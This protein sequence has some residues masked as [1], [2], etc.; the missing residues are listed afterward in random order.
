VPILA[1]HGSAD[2]IVPFNGGTDGLYH[3]LKFPPLSYSIDLWRSLDVCPGA[4]APTA[5]GKAEM[6]NDSTF[7]GGP[8]PSIFEGST[9]VYKQG[10]AEC[11]S[12]TGC[13]DGSEVE[14]CA[15]VGKTS[16]DIDAS[17][18]IIDFFEK[19]PMP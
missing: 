14:L 7:D 2:P 16:T 10:D 18:T 5:A 13:K 11:G 17:R 19:H 3:V 15:I 6:P 9:S 12:W 8:N 4:T 1:F